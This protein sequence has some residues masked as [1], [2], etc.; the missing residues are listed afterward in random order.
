MEWRL[1]LRGRA[2]VPVHQSL[3]FGLDAEQ[4][5]AIVKRQQHNLGIFLI[6]HRAVN[7][8][9]NQVNRI[10]EVLLAGLS[11]IGQIQHKDHKP[12]LAHNC[13]LS[14]VITDSTFW[15][16]CTCRWVR[17]FTGGYGW[18]FS[19]LC[20]KTRRGSSRTRLNSQ[21]NTYDRFLLYSTC[22]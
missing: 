17:W 5:Q 1:D 9:S 21:S 14:F 15:R 3:D 7:K 16:L 8:L 20:S 19:R 22:W 10:Q 2:V 4:L 18:F 13:A 12:L 11:I 6:L